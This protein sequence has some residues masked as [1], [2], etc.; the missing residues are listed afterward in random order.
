ME[1]EILSLTFR[2]RLRRGTTWN[3]VETALEDLISTSISVAR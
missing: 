3:A 1:I 2:L